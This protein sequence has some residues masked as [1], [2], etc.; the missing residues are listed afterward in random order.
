MIR[1]REACSS[2]LQMFTGTLTI[3]LRNSLAKSMQAFRQVNRQSISAQEENRHLLIK[4]QDT[5][6]RLK[7]MPETE[8]PGLD[9]KL[10]K[11]F[12]YAPTGVAQNACQAS[13]SQSQYM[14][15]FSEARIS[16]C[17]ASCVCKCH[18]IRY[19]RTP[20]LLARWLGRLSIESQPVIFV[21]QRKCDVKQCRPYNQ[22]SLRFFYSF[23]GW[24]LA[25]CFEVSLS[26]STLTG[27][28][29]SLHL[30]V[31]RVLDQHPVWAAIALGDLGWIKRSLSKKV[32]LPTD[33]SKDGQT[34]AFVRELPSGCNGKVVLTFGA[35]GS[36]E[37]PVPDCRILRTARV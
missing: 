32:I 35:D 18:Q 24:L 9:L 3:D 26:W 22:S 34:L 14:T 5:L 25:R 28:G 15:H 8:T 19:C 27:A 1:E 11:D 13:I 21:S 4:L 33:V 37:S 7:Q 10:E 30:R 23:P 16:A 29:S 31:P 6:D 2:W 36:L 17:E 20:K 12:A